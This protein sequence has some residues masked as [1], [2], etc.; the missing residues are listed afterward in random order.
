MRWTK[1]KAGKAENIFPIPL[2]RRS[3][4]YTELSEWLLPE[5]KHSSSNYEFRCVAYYDAK[6][7]ATPT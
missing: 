6:A 3:F 1:C 4:K 5:T 2:E 7:F